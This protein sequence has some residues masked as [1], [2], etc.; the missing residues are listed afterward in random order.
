LKAWSIDSGRREHRERSQRHARSSTNRDGSG[1]KQNSSVSF[2]M[3]RN[4]GDVPDFINPS[5]SGGAADTA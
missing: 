5:F 2:C 3:G 4:C 1:L